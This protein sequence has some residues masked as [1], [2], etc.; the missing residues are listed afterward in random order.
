MERI[1][2]TAIMHGGCCAVM[3]MQVDGAQNFVIVWKI[4][5]QDGDTMTPVLT[6]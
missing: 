3:V 5:A 2:M 1:T 6:N 4:T